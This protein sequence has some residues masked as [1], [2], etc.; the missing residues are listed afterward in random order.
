MNLLN[1]ILLIL[2]GIVVVGA[3]GFIIY[4]QNEMKTMQTQLNTAITAQQTL[5]DG[6]TRSSAQYATKSDLDAFAAQ[7]NVNLSVIQK[8]VAKLSATISGVNSVA[9]NSVGQNQN[10]LPSTSSTT[11]PT[12]K[13][14][15]N[16]VSCNGQQI[17]CPNTDPYGYQSTEQTFALS[18]PFS[19]TSSGATT[20]TPTQ[21]PIGSVGFSAANKAPWNVNLYPRS[22]NVT[23][24]LATDNNGKQTMYNQFSITTNGKSYTLPISTAKFEQQL[25]TSSF[26]F[27]NPHLFLTAGG[28]IDVSKL[29]VQGSA[30]IGATLGIMS[31][32]QT[33][34]SPTISVL[35]IGAA[36]ETG[37]S[38]PAAILNPISFN[39]GGIFPKGIVNNTYVGP[40]VQVDTGGNVFAGANV[41]VGF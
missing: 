35:Q 24:V 2:L 3:F 13:P 11:N 28:G 31:W 33:K 21:V 38:K 34:A 19:T 39:I 40:S 37:T 41:S 10:N 8:D 17:S 6:I 14:V 16:T 5:L 12:S 25:P 36:Y 9:V 20:S 29:P 30:N 22:Y 26:S 27:F 23:N 15:S 1:K 4:Q 18:E 32:G 7:N